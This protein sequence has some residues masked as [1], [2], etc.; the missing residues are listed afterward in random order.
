MQTVL[1]VG[2]KDA[3]H[4][5]LELELQKDFAV[6]RCESAEE[7]ML[8]LQLHNPDCLFCDLRLPGMDGLFFMKQMLE[9]LPSVIFTL[10]PSY[11]APVEQQ[12]LDMGVAYPLLSLCPVRIAAQHVRFFLEN[13]DAQQ[14]ECAQKTVAAHLR[15]LGVPNQGG[16]DDLRVGTPLFAH[17]PCYQS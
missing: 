3:F 9:F 6:Y 5:E 15:I 7:G 1:I 10:A 12:L 8:L 14:K 17:N 11:S 2:A 4:D 16:F 13:Q